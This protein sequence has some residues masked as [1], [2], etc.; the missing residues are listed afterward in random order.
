MTATPPIGAI[1]GNMIWITGFFPREGNSDCAADIT[2]SVSSSVSS[3]QVFLFFKQAVIGKFP[4][5]LRQL[6]GSA[7]DIK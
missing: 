2:P 5:M 4:A 6:G 1:Y 7:T 3:P